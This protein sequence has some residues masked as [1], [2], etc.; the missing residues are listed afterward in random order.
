[1]TSPHARSACPG[2][3]T[4]PVSNGLTA[5]SGCLV[6]AVAGLAEPGDPEPIARVR[7]HL[8]DLAAE[9]VGGGV[10]TGVAAAIL[11]GDGMPAAWAVRR[12][13]PRACICRRGWASFAGARRP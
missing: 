2:R 10:I 5:T 6:L 8:S 13:M 3:Y 7:L 12:V 9:A 11:G 4:L 1:M